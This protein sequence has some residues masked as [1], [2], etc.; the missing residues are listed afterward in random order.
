[1]PRH[2]GAIAEPRGD[3]QRKFEAHTEAGVRHRFVNSRLQHSRFVLRPGVCH[4]TK[5]GD[6][7]GDRD[8]E[9]DAPN[10]PERDHSHRDSDWNAL[11]NPSRKQHETHD[12][13]D[14][15]HR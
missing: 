10:Q 11:S 7:E 12:E 5:R 14:A 2:Q 15:Q 3:Q 13:G 9:E 8:G 1:M 6:Q 4:L